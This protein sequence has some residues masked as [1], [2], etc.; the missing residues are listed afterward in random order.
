MQT[1]NAGGAVASDEIDS[2]ISSDKPSAQRF[3]I[4]RESTSVPCTI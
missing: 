3:I 2:L 1:N 4:V